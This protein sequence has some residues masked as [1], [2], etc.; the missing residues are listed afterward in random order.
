MAQAV[1]H[2]GTASLDHGRGSHEH[3]LDSPHG[4]GSQHSEHGHGAHGHGEHGGH[5]EHS[6]LHHHFDDMEQQREATAL[7]MWT[8]L[9][10]EVMMFGAL[11]FAYSLYRYKF[12]TEWLAGSHSLNFQ[13]G[14]FNTL[15]LLCSSLTMAMGVHAAQMRQ[16]NRMQLF[17]GLT[18]VLGLA[19]LVIKGIEWS[20][21]Y[22][23]GLVPGM[24]WDPRPH[25]LADITKEGFNLQGYQMYFVVYFS[26]TGLHAFHMVIGLGLVAYFMFLGQRGMFTNGNDQPVELLGLYWHFVDIVW[27]FLFPLLYL[28]GGGHVAK[29]FGGGGAH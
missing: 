25:N 1:E 18:W 23:E 9:S 14:F 20:A 13:L 4:P 29:I 24:N 3:S 11:M 28:I 22:H 21:D 27:V 7:G 16:K 19:F 17:L 12:G 8:F 26:M 15:V 2:V 5:G 6:I 10:T